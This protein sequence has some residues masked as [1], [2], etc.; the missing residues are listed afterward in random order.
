MATSAIPTTGING[1]RF[2]SRIEAQWAEMFTKLGWEWEYEPI[3]LKGYIPDFILKFPHR[4]VLVEVKGDTDIKN[5]EQYAD[6]IVKSGW[7]GEFLLVC[8]VLPEIAEDDNNISIGLLGGVIGCEEP[9]YPTY[10]GGDY[11]RL[12]TCESCKNTTFYSHNYTWTCRYCGEWSKLGSKKIC[13]EYECKTCVEC[14]KYEQERIKYEPIRK[15]ILDKISKEKDRYDITNPEHITYLKR[16]G[17]RS[18]RHICE[19]NKH[20]SICKICYDVPEIPKIKQF[21][22]FFGKCLCYFVKKYGKYDKIKQFWYESK[23]NVQ[24][25]KS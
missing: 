13:I 17:H 20:Y 10:D 7:D 9:I 18:G 14:I 21:K 12:S 11:A 19:H 4:H 1:I 15:I 23:N 16:F 24:W 2:R 3:D 25:K 8:S 5:I 6:K 22:Q